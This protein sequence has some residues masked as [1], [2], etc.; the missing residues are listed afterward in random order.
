M[1]DV[2][3]ARTLKGLRIARRGVDRHSGQ[4][5]AIKILAKTRRKSTREKTL[6]K[7]WKEAACLAAVQVRPPPYQTADR[8][9]SLI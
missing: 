6:K 1:A 2:P 7:I 4:E 5:V 3:D 8:Y 9:C